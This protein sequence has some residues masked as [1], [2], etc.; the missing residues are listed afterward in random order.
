MEHHNVSTA[1][2]KKRATHWDIPGTVYDLYQRVVKNMS[3]MQF[4]EAE[5]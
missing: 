3:I 4:D 2:F 5:T 1:Q